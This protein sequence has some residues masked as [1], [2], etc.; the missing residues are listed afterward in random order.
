MREKEALDM[1]AALESKGEVE[2][3]VCQLKKTVTI[4][5]KMVTIQ[6]E[7]KIEHQR[8]FTP[9][10]IEP[11]FGIGRIIYCLYEHSFYM[12]PSKAG[13]EELRV[14]RFPALVAPIKCT[15]FPLVQ[16][17]TFEAVSKLISKSLTA[18]DVSHK[19]DITGMLIKSKLSLKCMS[20][21]LYQTQVH[22]NTS[23]INP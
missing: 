22:E 11:S 6:K 10:V 18:A 17:Q 3:E 4:N 13:D 5:K 21:D 8:V 9:S 12:R 14:F 15:V 1:K 7:K 23:L 2:F 20:R 19:V 16:N